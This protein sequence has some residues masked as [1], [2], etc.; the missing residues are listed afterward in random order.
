MHTSTVLVTI[1]DNKEIDEI[2]IDE[3]DLEVT[4]TVGSG[5]GGQH[6]NRTYSCVT[7]HHLPSGLKIRIDGRNQHQNYREAK[8]EIEKKL[9]EE[10]NNNFKSEQK[11]DKRSQIGINNR[12]NKKRTYNVKTGLVKDHVSGKKTSLRNVYK[13]KIKELH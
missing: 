7:M 2:N 12:S 10:Y 5:P 11:K 3:N 6:K 8:K 9:Q 4:Y 13:G 1:V